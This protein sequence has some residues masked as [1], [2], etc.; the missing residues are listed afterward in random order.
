MP[1]RARAFVERI[2]IKLGALLH[3]DKSV[4]HDPTKS[5]GKIPHSKSHSATGG[6][7]NSAAAPNGTSRHTNDGLL[8]AEK[9]HPQNSDTLDHAEPPRIQRVPVGRPNG[10]MPKAT[11]RE[12]HQFEKLPDIDTGDTFD[13]GQSTYRQST[14]DTT[15][16][17]AA[18]KH[19]EKESVT[20]RGNSFGLKRDTSH[21]PTGTDGGNQFENL[22]GID[23][24][25]TV[26]TDYDT[27]YAP[28]KLLRNCFN[29]Y[30]IDQVTFY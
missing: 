30:P 1:R 28:G 20:N 23:L 17:G 12:D 3:K 19:L 5:N 4:T 27:N 21:L 24:N 25:D 11:I 15:T 2:T 10:S 16:D 6:Q 7:H 8:N 22:P 26:D 13:V 18:E 29:E 9:S 14:N